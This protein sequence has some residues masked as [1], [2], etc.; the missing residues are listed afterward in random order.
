MTSTSFA[1]E[2]SALADTSR[3]WRIWFGLA[4]TLFWLWLGVMYVAVVIGVGNFLS[5]PADA[6]GGFL[7]GAFA[8]LAF[9]WLV[10]GFFL[11]QRELRHN[12]AAI[13]LQY[14]QMRR[15]VAHAETQA[16]AIQANALHQEQETL[17]LVADRVHRQ[18]GSVVGLLWMS[19]RGP[20]N[21]D[22]APEA[23]ISELWSRL[24]SGDSEAFAR[25]CMAFYFVNRSDRAR[26]YDFFLGTPVRAR[27]SET[28]VE[29][30]DRLLESA[31]SCDPNRIITNALLGS[32]HGQVYRIVQE[33][34][35]LGP[36]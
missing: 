21:P 7:E 26:V 27:H 13:R 17:L 36:P 11:Q 8:P 35:Q 31:R 4:S 28:V 16:R 1:T 14:E 23:L 15:Q 22:S 32:A 9:L 10:I 33:L 29:T 20:G 24:G 5:Q 18:L 19:S 12:N 30:Y 2:P 6:V 25:Q 3:D 34:K